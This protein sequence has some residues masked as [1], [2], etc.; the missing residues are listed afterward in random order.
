MCG[1]AGAPGRRA[2]L[3]SYI[4]VA[5]CPAPTLQLLA[6]GPAIAACWPR[7]PPPAVPRPP[8]RCVKTLQSRGIKVLG[9]AVLNHRCA[10]RQG[11]GG[12]WNQF[13]GRMSWD[14]RAI[15]GDHSEY[16]GSGNLSSGELF[17]AAPNIDHSQVRAGGG[18]AVRCGVWGGPGGCH[19]QAGRVS[20]CLLAACWLPPACCIPL[21]LASLPFFL[22]LP[23][24]PALLLPA[25]R[26]L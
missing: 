20:C 11:Q 15:V 25:C 10:Q 14:E 3:V 21:P 6:C 19:W 9:D 8:R 26:T 22:P 4:A 13:G 1:S 24:L 2:Q 12:V 23:A 17:G 18:G 16:R 7:S 5:P